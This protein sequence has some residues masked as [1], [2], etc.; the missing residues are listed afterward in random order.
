MST[1]APSQTPQ[2]LESSE[3][4][5]CRFCGEEIRT[6]AVKCKHCGEFLDESLRQ[7]RA[8]ELAPALPKWNPGIAAVCS[9]FIP[10]LGQ[11]YKGQV[12]NGLAWF[13]VVIVGYFFL[14]IPGLVLHL[15]CIIGAASG[16]PRK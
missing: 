8:K 16:D 4:K 14:V 2:S 7:G 11:L 9:F 3:L 5:L 10:G 12:F 13:L 1:E 15:F 6:S